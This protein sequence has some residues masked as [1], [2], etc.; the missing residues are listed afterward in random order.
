VPTAIRCQNCKKSL[1]VPDTLIGKRIKCPGCGHA[2][3][4]EPPEEEPTSVV[5]IDEEAESRKPER[6]TQPP[7]RTSS[8][9]TDADDD[10]EHDDYAE[11]P[12]PRKKARQRRAME[13]VKAPAI[14]L[15]AAGGIGFVLAILNLAVLLS[16]RGLLFDPNLNRP[17]PPAPG[18]MG[19]TKDEGVGQV[20]PVPFYI[21]ASVSVLWGIIVS[22]G[23]YMMYNLKARSSVMF[24][25]I[26]AMLP[27]NLCCL[28]GLPFG[29]WALVVIGRP[30]VKGAF[31]S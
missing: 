6:G 18:Q 24:A 17:P 28:L 26:F 20:S 30:E 12:A 21:G 22:I 1:R 29:I 11:T 7:P 9:G 2:F 25:S 27:C 4:A 8:A 15:M 13:A 14:A 23:G 3:V 31:E 10:E 16:G 19:Q 5:E